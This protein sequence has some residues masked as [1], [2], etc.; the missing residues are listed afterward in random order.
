MGALAF[1]FFFSHRR[2]W[3]MIESDTDGGCAV[4]LAGETNRNFLGFKDRFNKLD[5]TVKYGLGLVE[6]ER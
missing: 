4:I 3:A 6:K 1:V 5:E 2:Y